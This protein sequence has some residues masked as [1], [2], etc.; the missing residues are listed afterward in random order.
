MLFHNYFVSC[1]YTSL[2]QPTLV[3]LQTELKNGNSRGMTTNYLI[4]DSCGGIDDDDVD[5]DDDDGGGDDKD[6]N[7]DITNVDNN[8]DAK[9]CRSR[10]LT[11]V[12]Y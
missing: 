10:F 5:N 7:D 6:E 1:V 11:L 12:S 3:E 4:Y 8:D 9:S 2:W